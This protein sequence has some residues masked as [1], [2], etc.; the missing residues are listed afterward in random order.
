MTLPYKR[1]L[2]KLSGERFGTIKDGKD[3]VLDVD[4]ISHM[5]DEIISVHDE[6]TEVG[7]VL[8]AGNIVRGKEAAAAGIEEAQAHQ[9][10]MIA[11]VINALSLQSVLEKK[12]KFTRVMSA[13]PMSSVAEPY[14]RRRAIRHMEKG[15]VVIMAGGTGNPFF[16]TD[17]AGALRA[18]ELRADMLVKATKVDGIYTA[19]PKTDKTAKH[20]D[21]IS[22]KDVLVEDLKVM[23]GAA[24]AICR[25]NKLPLMV[26]SVDGAGSLL[27]AIKG[28]AKRT[29]VK[30]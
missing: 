19:D 2:I 18:V 30:A 20:L 3:S 13:I 12:G 23:D 10:G 25:E 27:K 5:A 16:S 11:T 15:R 26:C 29:L 28:K 9:M 4:Q 1:I 6:G 17:T 21:E 22:Y 7:V 14:I 24:I 8:G